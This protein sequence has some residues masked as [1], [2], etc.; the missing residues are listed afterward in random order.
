MARVTTA[1]AL[2]IAIPVLLLYQFLSGKVD[3]IVDDLDEMGMEFMNNCADEIKDT[4][5]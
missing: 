2:T 4:G 1:T 5:V 3:T